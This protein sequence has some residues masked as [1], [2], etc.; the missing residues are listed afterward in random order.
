MRLLSLKQ[1]KKTNRLRGENNDNEGEGG[2]R[3][4]GGLVEFIR[5]FFGS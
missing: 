3:G 5:R 1:Y 2:G 4:G